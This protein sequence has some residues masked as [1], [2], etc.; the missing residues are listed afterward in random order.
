MT[1]EEKAD[2]AAKIDQAIKQHDGARQDDDIDTRGGTDKMLTSVTDA[3]QACTDAIKGLHK[4]MDDLEASEGKAKKGDGDG[5]TKPAP[6]RLGEF[7]ATDDDDSDLSWDELPPDE[8]A[9]LVNEEAA[10]E[11]D[12]AREL[13][14]DSARKRYDEALK[15][16]LRFDR[17]RRRDSLLTDARVAADAAYC[18]LGHDTPKPMS[19][20]SVRAYRRRLLQP[21]LRHSPN[22]KGI[23]MRN[24]TDPKV[25]AIA[26]QQIFADGVAEG[27]RPTDVAPG[28]LIVRE[29]KSDGHIIREFY[30]DPR[31]WMDPMAGATQLRAVGTWLHGNL[32][33]N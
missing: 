2:L 11:P 3:V 15:R 23:D 25:F 33:K 5:V 4:R 12:Q 18:A 30:G 19:G 31:S 10:R 29:R 22:Y 28:R 13:T 32:N 26:E 16:E 21:L 20:E 14:A 7:G 1:N 27:R 24:I 17:Q 6:R 9:R 8:Q